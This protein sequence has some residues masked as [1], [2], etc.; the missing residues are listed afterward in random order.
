METNSLIYMEFF[1]VF[2]NIYDKLFHPK[3]FY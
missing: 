1:T 2:G 3:L